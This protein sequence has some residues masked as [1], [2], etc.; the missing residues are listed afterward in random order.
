MA[1]PPS[2]TGALRALASKV[3]AACRLAQRRMADVD[4]EEHLMYDFFGASDALLAALGRLLRPPAGACPREALG[5]ARIDVQKAV[6]LLE[7]VGVRAVVRDDAATEHV[8]AVIDVGFE[9]AVAPDAADVGLDEEYLGAPDDE[10]WRAGGD[11]EDAGEV[12]VHSEGGHDGVGDCEFAG[13]WAWAVLGGGGSATAPTVASTGV[14]R[15]LS[16][17]RCAL[18]LHLADWRAHVVSLQAKTA[19]AA[20][21][22]ATVREEGGG[23]S[24]EA[25][26]DGQCV[27]PARGFLVEDGDVVDWFLTKEARTTQSRLKRYHFKAEVSELMEARRI[28]WLVSHETRARPMGPTRYRFRAAPE[29]RRGGIFAAEG[30]ATGAT[31]S[32]TTTFA[33]P[34]GS[35]RAVLPEECS[36]R[37]FH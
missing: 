19:L 2:A 36:G 18:E 28:E 1:V 21:V 22:L 3:G 11:L 17:R 10:R 27:V 32:S 4:D 14:W 20:A 37:A 8:G 6:R 23:V 26:C 16:A 15:P 35:A 24:E 9:G 5:S 33:F 12:P 31:L 13:G 29:I 25:H 30:E 7:A 34:R